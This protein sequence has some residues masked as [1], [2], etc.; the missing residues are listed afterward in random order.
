MYIKRPERQQRRELG[1]ECYLALKR[2][3]ALFWN[4]LD[5]EERQ[6]QS[7]LWRFYTDKE[8]AKLFNQL[9]VGQRPDEAQTNLELIFA[10]SNV[11]DMVAEFNH[12]DARALH[13]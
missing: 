2:F 10:A 7:T 9:I 13:T 3:S 4:H 8:L 12:V 5:R 11:N 1:S 6:T